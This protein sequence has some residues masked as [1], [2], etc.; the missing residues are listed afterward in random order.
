M[1]AA[2][3]EP[4]TAATATPLGPGPI[5]FTVDPW[6]PGY[7]VALTVEALTELDATTAELDLDIEMPA[8]RWR[9]LTAHPATVL[10]SVL[11]VADGVRRIDARVWVDNPDGGMPTPGIAASYATGLGCCDRRDGVLADLAGVEVRRAL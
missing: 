7:A 1:T 10:P 2:E 3:P 9:A 6:D 4:N 5:G 8:D 11:L